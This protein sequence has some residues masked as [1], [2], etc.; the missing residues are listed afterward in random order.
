MTNPIIDKFGN[1]RW[2]NSKGQL[3]RDDGP[4]EESWYYKYWWRNGE[5]HREDGP[6]AEWNNGDKWWYIQG[7]RIT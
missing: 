6:A 4:A 2:Y 5:L 7:K 1:K 3:H